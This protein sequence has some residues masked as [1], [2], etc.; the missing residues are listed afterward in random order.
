MLYWIGRYEV[1]FQTHSSKFQCKTCNSPAI[2]K[3][4]EEGGG[5]QMCFCP[6]QLCTAYSEIIDI[7][8]KWSLCLSP[9]HGYTKIASISLNLTILGLSY[10]NL[11]ILIKSIFW[12]CY[13]MVIV[14]EVWEINRF[15][16][17]IQP[18]S[19]TF[20]MLVLFLMFSTFSMLTLVT[21]SASVSSMFIL[22]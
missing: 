20:T 12:I 6:I 1:V 2:S 17:P 5:D 15:T 11:K 9:V 18:S 3:K 19:T 8:F 21:P 13:G 16:S 7:V 10:W 14:W 22:L 4:M